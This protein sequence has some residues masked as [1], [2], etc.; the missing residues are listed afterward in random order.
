M[1]RALFLDRDGII[2]HEVGYLY[3]SVDV[4]WVDGIFSL[5]RAATALGYKLVVITN[6]SGIARGFYSEADFHALMAWMSAE[7]VAQGAPLSAVYFCPF[8]P[9]HGV[10]PYKREHPDRKPG[11][12]M[13]LRA[14]ADL[15]LDLPNSILLGDRC[16]D[17]A[18]AHAAGL[19]HAFLLAG[20]EQSPCPHPAIEIKSLREMEQWLT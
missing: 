16:S 9:D 15:S 20:T 19:R 18:A 10:G 13:L 5:C 17:I 12:G 1:T 2:N 11:P 4:L 8:H 14:A 7:F 6:Q 3:R